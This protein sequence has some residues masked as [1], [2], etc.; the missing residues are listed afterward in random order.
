MA[1]RVEPVAVL[2][3]GAMGHGMAASALRAGIPTT[4]WDRRIKAAR[5]QGTLAALAPA[6]IWAQM[7]TIGVRGTDRVMALASA[8]RPDVIV[9][10]APGAGRQG[11]GRTRRGARGLLPC[12]AR[13]ASNRSGSARPG[14]ARG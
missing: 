8:E 1:G 5:D 6:A 3:I 10:D 13:S 2:G 12:S 7:S 14:A 11:P 9:L 4:V